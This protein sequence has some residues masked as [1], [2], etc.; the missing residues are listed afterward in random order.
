MP[1]VLY[2]YPLPQTKYI[3]EVILDEIELSQVNYFEALRFFMPNDSIA[4]EIAKFCTRD[5][6]LNQTEFGAQGRFK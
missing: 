4:L 3:I 6:I 5:W 2:I 1:S